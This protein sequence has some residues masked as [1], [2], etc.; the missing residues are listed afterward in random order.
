MK[1]FYTIL[2][3]F[4]TF[5]IYSQI[6]NKLQK[7]VI[8]L[9]S[10]KAFKHA[11]IGLCVYD[12]N[13]KKI[14]VDINAE[15]TLIPAST[16][17]VLT[18]FTALNHLS[19][20]FEYE[21]K[22]S[23]SGRLKNG[24]LKGN[25][26]IQGSG[27]PTL[28]SGKL[29]AKHTKELIKEIVKTIKAKGIKSITGKVI[30]DE[31]IF[32]S[33]PISPS[34]QWNDIG[35]YYATGAWGININDNLY[36]AFFGDR[37]KV[38]DQPILKGTNPVIPG[39]SISNELTLDSA[40]TEDQAY[41]FGGPYN[42]KKRIVGTIPVGKGSFSIRGAIPDPPLFFA[43]SIATSL[44]RNGIKTGGAESQYH[45]KHKKRNTI[46]TINSPKFGEIVRECLFKSNNLY[47]ESILKTMAYDKYKQGTGGYG[48]KMIFDLMAKLGLDANSLHMEDGSGL[49]VRNGV[50]PMLLAK[51]VGE[52]GN[53]F[54]QIKI[55]DYLPK[56]GRQGTVRGLNIKGDVW[57]KSGSMHD[58]QCFTGIIE[59]KNGYAYSYSI[60][61]NRFDIEQSSM[62]TKLTK[63]LN[64]ISKRL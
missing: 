27:D 10:H 11:S 26:Y 41:V 40:G 31:S 2:L 62:V 43:Q 13:C 56:M 53:K 52:Y 32:D 36:T 29:G 21:T 33:F 12:F 48:I 38:G 9:F 23:Y 20:D 8:E 59:D 3:C 15:K 28:G 58:I 25:I 19:A 45:S 46:I 63:I 51:F 37:K 60:M 42:F 34:W 35:N 49:S 4:W 17:K 47:C 6:D 22:I 64:L 55:A 39:M 14:V 57:G 7:E 1:Y 5:C 24:V 18:C 44:K 30:A 16:L 61:V 54:D 50:S